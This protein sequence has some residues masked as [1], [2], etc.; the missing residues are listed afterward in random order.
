MRRPRLLAALAPLALALAGCGSTPH[1]PSIPSSDAAA[2]RWSTWVLRA[3]DQVFVPPPPAHGSPAARSAGAGLA[4][5]AA[6]S[7]RLDGRWNRRSATEPW[8]NL[9]LQFVAERSIDPP[10]AA[11]AYAL[12]SVAMYD[13]V[14][15]REYWEERYGREGYPSEPAVVAGA[16]SRTLAYL[17]PRHSRASLDRLADQAAVAALRAGGRPGDVSAGLRLGRAVGARVV[18]YARTDGSQRRWDGRRPHG[19]AAWSPPLG[20]S[21]PPQD[22]LAGG[23]RTW[24]LSSGSQFRPPPPPRFGSPRYVAEARELVRLRR[25]L[26]PQQERIA[27]FWAGGVGSPLPPGVWN[28]VALAYARRDRLDTD[29]AARV[30]ALLNVA[31]A[32]AGVATWDAKYAYWT[33]RPENAIRTLGLDRRWTSFLA[34]PAFPSYVSAH[35]SFSGAA[36]EVLG[37]LFPKDA[38]QFRAKADQAGLSRLY[39]GIHF[40]ADHVAGIE[41]G[42]S[43]GRLVIARWR[44]ADARRAP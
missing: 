32:D 10:R 27:Q 21:D 36:S 26:T 14:V 1:R 40:R 13:A 22:P 9:S 29:D 7:P 41:L 17:F 8:T 37:A 25:A 5:L 42:R 28:Q 38:R 12:V 43:V 11:R 18:V 16:A 31:Q 30:F 3:P 19:P 20:T 39:G 6:R 44:A 34:T 2:A 4:R 24:V 15:S 23:W 33:A 35:S